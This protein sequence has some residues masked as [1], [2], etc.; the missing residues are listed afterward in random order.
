MLSA[1]AQSHCCD[2]QADRP[3]DVEGE[4]RD[5][6]A[7]TLD[8]APS[9]V[10]VRVIMDDTPHARRVQERSDRIRA[11]R[12]Q[13]RAIEAETAELVRELA[14]DGV[15]TRDIATLTR[16]AASPGAR[17]REGR[18]PTGHLRHAIQAPPRQQFP[19]RAFPGRA[20]PCRAHPGSPPYIPMLKAPCAL[21]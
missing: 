20:C 12:A 14:K 4:A 1:T 5:Y 6:L 15:P 16:V 19:G 7:V 10:N 17:G 13:V 18:S 2:G 11:A 9:T 8:V 21:G 3:A